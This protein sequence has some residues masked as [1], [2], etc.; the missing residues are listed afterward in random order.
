MDWKKKIVTDFVQHAG[1]Q[2]W[3]VSDPDELVR[4]ESVIA[5][6]REKGFECL[7]FDDPIEFRYEYESRI[8]RAWER[9]KDLPLIVLFDEPLS[10][11]DS[12]PS[13]LLVSAARLEFSLRHVFPIYD[14]EVLRELPLAMWDKLAAHMASRHGKSLNHKETAELALRLCYQLSSDLIDSVPELIRR[15]IE[16]HCNHQGLP[17]LLALRFASDLKKR[18]VFKNFDLAR[19]CADQDFFWHFLK[20]NW[21]DFIRMS[22]GLKPELVAEHQLL[23][24]NDPLL[25][26][27][28]ES[29]LEKGKIDPIDLHGIK[30]ADHH[31]WSVGV[32][33]AITDDSTI[34]ESDLLS[35]KDLIPTANANSREWIDFALI[36]SKL[37]SKLFC[38]SASNLQSAFWRDLWTEVDSRFF[39]WL[40]FYYGGLYNLPAS[41]PV[42]QHHIPKQLNRLRIERKK[43]ALLLLDGLSMAGWSTAH[44]LLSEQLPSDYKYQTSGVFSWLP[45]LTPFCRQSVF[46]GQAPRLFAETLTRTDKDAARWQSFWQT[47]AELRPSQI[48]HFQHHGKPEECE[49]FADAL[50]GKIAVGVTVTMPDEIMH[51]VSLG[52]PAWHQ[53]L[54]LWMQGGYLKQLIEQLMEQGFTV[55]ITADHGNLEA[56]GTGKINEGVLAGSRGQRTRLYSNEDLRNHAFEANPEK[57]QC[58]NTP[59]LPG[60]Q[61][62]LFAKGRGAFIKEG[63]V[64]VTHGGASLD[65]MIVPWVLLERSS[66]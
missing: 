24:F 33:K 2:V 59:I 6:L 21:E 12:I 63:D 31:W 55:A 17:E 48:S 42:M 45:S 23:P 5:Q 10:G 8:R 34:L 11:F 64:V 32:K 35:L 51:G 54:N 60:N 61:F 37:V 38:Q 65:E 44:R 13:D 28:L 26:G 43:V 9:G 36:Y 52:W 62:P 56:I 20:S 22:V 25:R 40:E 53:E 30:V 3:A 58:F 19:L 39:S 49:G 29:L 4:N 47:H 7:F 16:L 57:S 46:Y 41:P 18:K 66:Q 15:L 50:E 1:T 27:Y 14:A